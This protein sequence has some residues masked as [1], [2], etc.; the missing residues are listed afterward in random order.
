MSVDCRDQRPAVW[1]W[2]PVEGQNLTRIELRHKSDVMNLAGY[3][4]N[5]AEEPSVP[6]ARADLMI[7]E[8]T[9]ARLLKQ[10]QNEDASQTDDAQFLKEEMDGLHTEMASDDDFKAYMLGMLEESIQDGD[11]A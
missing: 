5:P 10:R 3:V 11:K 1:S 9:F 2:A 7:K 4:F 6:E 8:S